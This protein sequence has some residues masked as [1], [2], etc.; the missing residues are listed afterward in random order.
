MSGGLSV[1]NENL[2]KVATSD[3]KNPYRYLSHSGY[4]LIQITPDWNNWQF[5]DTVGGEKLMG[6]LCNVTGIL[7]E[8]FTYSIES[9]WSPIKTPFDFGIAEM[10]GDISSA[11]GGGAIGEVFTSKQ[12]WHNSGYVKLSPKFRIYDYDGLGAASIAAYVMTRYVSSNFNLSD[13]PNQMEEHVLNWA[14]HVQDESFEVAPQGY[15][16]QLNTEDRIRKTTLRSLAKGAEDIADYFTV[17]TSPPPM[18]I[19]IGR[20]FNKRDMIATNLNIE[21]S[22]EYSEAGPLWVDITLDISSRTIVRGVR[23]TGIVSDNVGEVIVEIEG[24]NGR[25]TS[26]NVNSMDVLTNNPLTNF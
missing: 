18:H 7:T 14:T 11:L 12:V 13:T 25:K 19:C 21:Y 22:S 17:K 5:P 1:V 9:N 2:W 15:S 4:G 24:D 23:D 3:A 10:A 8:P 26:H 6:L 20:V 16:G